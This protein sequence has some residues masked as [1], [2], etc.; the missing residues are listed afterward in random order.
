M[1]WSDR[2]IVRSNEGR[3]GQFQSRLIGNEGELLRFEG[4]ILALR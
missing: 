4:C 3:L 1:K 2:D